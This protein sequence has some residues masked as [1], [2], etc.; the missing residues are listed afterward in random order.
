MPGGWVAVATLGEALLAALGGDVG[1]SAVA[2]PRVAAQGLVGVFGGVSQ[3]ARELGVPRSTFRGWLAGRQPSAGMAG[4]LEEFAREE[5]RQAQ[6]DNDQWTHGPAD[7]SQLRVVGTYD[8]AAGKG[9]RSDENRDIPLGQYM[10]ASALAELRQAYADGADAEELHEIAWSA[11][12]DGGFYSKTF[13]PDGH[14]GEWDVQS[15]TGI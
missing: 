1:P 12:N 6:A 7:I 3:A 15:I 13:D 5:W 11:I 8:Y 10:D 2:S 14:A 4:Q 9:R